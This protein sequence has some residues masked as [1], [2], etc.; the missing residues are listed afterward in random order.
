MLFNPVT[1][2]C[3]IRYSPMTIHPTNKSSC[4][5]K[6][7]IDRYLGSQTPRS[8]WASRPS[9]HERGSRRCLPGTAQPQTGLH[10]GKSGKPAGKER[11]QASWR[12]VN[13]IWNGISQIGRVSDS[14]DVQT[15]NKAAPA[16]AGFIELPCTARLRSSVK[17]S[18][19]TAILVCSYA[20]E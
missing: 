11:T 10:G 19:A 18:F 17:R 1:F 14:A 7:A 6:L 3:C 2:A 20:Q 13:Q 4:E 5:L 9:R 16:A 8:D 15:G 12:G